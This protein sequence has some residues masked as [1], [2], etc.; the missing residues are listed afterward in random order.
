MPDS[1]GHLNEFNALAPSTA[2]ASVEAQLGALLDPNADRIVF[3]DDSAGVFAFLAPGTG[4][5]ISGTTMDA[6]ASGSGTVTS[7]N[8]T[9]PAAGLTVSG[10]PITTSGA[11]T[12]ALANDLAAL[13]ALSGTNTLYYRSAAD[14]WSAVTIGSLLSF[15][16]GTLNVG[17][18]ELQ[19]IAGLTSAADKGIQF[20]GSGTAATFD[21][22]TA[23]KTILD[24]PSVT[25]MRT[26]LGVGLA[27][28]R[29]RVDSVNG[30]DGTGT[31]GRD[32]L[33]YLT[34]GAAK[35]AASSGD[36]I[37]VGPGTYNEKNLSKNGVNWHFEAGAI[38]AYSGAADGGVFDD[39]SNGANGATSFHVTGAG[40]FTHS[41]GTTFGAS[42]A[43]SVVVC[44][45]GSS[46]VIIEAERIAITRSGSIDGTGAVY[47]S[48]GTITVRAI[49][50]SGGTT[51]AG[52]W[53]VG[54]E[55]YITADLI[56][57]ASYGVYSDSIE[58]TNMWIEAQRIECT[59]GEGMAIY[60]GGQT[61]NA[62][63]WVNAKEIINSGTPGGGYA[64]GLVGFGKAYVVA[65]KI[66]GGAISLKSQSSGTSWVTAQKITAISGAT[67]AVAMTATPTLH[68]DVQQIE[69][70]GA[71]AAL[72]SV[73]GL[74]T[75]T[76]NLRGGIATV[77]GN[78]DALSLAS[79]TV[80]VSDFTLNTAATASASPI[81]K[82]GGTLT[83][84]SVILI[85]EGTRDSITAGSSQTV[86]NLGGFYANRPING[87]ITLSPNAGYYIDSTGVLTLPNVNGNTIAAGTGTIATTS[88]AYITPGAG[89]ATALAVNVGSAGAFVVLGGALGTPSSGVA[90]NLTGLPINTG[91]TI[92]SQAQGD[93]LYYNGSAWTRLGAG[94]SGQFL[95][96]FGSGANPA[97][98]TIAGGGDMVLADIQTVTGAKTFADGTLKLAGS[99]S[100]AVTLA[101]PA[102]AGSGTMTVPAGVGTLVAK[103][104]TD[105]FSN[106]T[107]DNTT[108]A[109]IKDANFALQATGD[110]TKQAKFELGGI[111]TGTTRTYTVPDASMTLV[112]ADTTQTL[113]NK[114]LTSPTLTTPAL[115]TPAS[116]NAANLTGLPFTLTFLTAAI[117][118]AD[119]TTYYAG[120]DPTGATPTSYANARVEM[121]KAGT[122]KGYSLKVRCAAGSNETVSHY[123]RINDTTDFG[124]V[125]ST[126]DAN[127]RDL[128]VSG[129]SQAVAVGD[130]LALKIVC[131]TWATNPT[132]VRWY[133]V[134]YLET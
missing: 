94:T 51:S 49:E 105:T 83:I 125:D 24:D 128:N 107:L 112:G 35:T 79:G 89:V 54:G 23:A 22:T 119:A 104:T 56:K 73:S 7:I 65:E 99:S 29:L 92:A 95:K 63:L 134:V 4:L 102:A 96:T 68:L 17:D 31:R 34:L 81:N 78:I 47:Q 90:T 122:V 52:A 123:L 3:W 115:G 130:F 33:P 43:N 44:S 15:S 80:N 62:R 131:P 26:T 38:V 98:A 86:Q 18:A 109:N 8:L 42:P 133:V 127:V 108:V 12:L 67:N 121:R 129:L 117:T 66:S 85:A 58:A 21:L 53:W 1:I 97:W 64:L 71:S 5:T 88:L 60:T 124:Q 59:S 20:T 114:T 16:G 55:C 61:D 19:A 93:V 2:L 76:L 48:D 74:G 132:L 126:Y 82:S 72:I 40:V 46:E 32:D 25:A 111:T 75:K 120:G 103:D 28:K 37:V 27:G 10:G 91:L 57:G 41:G 118:A 87:N 9:A 30:N 39:G 14:T 36:V 6:S 113:T 69:D 106:K 77:A 11:I 116:G 110:A 101:A 50:I 70:L 13:E 84:S 45:N 100:G